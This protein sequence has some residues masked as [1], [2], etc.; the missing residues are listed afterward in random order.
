M[1]LPKV[2][3]SGGT[4][5]TQD[6]TSMQSQWASK[7]DPLIESHIQ[8]DGIPVGSIWMWPT[9]NPPDK[10]LACN[11]AIVLQQQYLSLFRLIGTTYNTGGEPAGSYRL[12][13]PSGPFTLIIKAFP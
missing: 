8:G 4:P 1:S 9:S 6:F 12:P 13:A 5:T 3:P 11:S 2:Q 10:F 7:I